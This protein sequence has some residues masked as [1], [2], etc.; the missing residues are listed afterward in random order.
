MSRAQKTEGRKFL[1]A[2]NFHTSLLEE[3]RPDFPER[4]FREETRFSGIWALARANGRV[5]GL[6][7]GYDRLPHFR[8]VNANNT[9]Q[10]ASSTNAL[11]SGT[12]SGEKVIE[13]RKK[14]RR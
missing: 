2:S 8:W 7:N 9:Q 11:G 3:L 12:G 14:L 10:T 1:R 4:I 13:S 5:K 6:D